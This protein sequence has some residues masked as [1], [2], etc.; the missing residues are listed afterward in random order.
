MISIIAAMTE[1]H[2]IARDGGIPWHVPEDLKL[3]RELTTGHAVVMGRKTFQSMGKPLKG[4]LNIVISS[5]LRGTEDDLREDN[6]LICPS[7]EEA[8]A[9][10]EGE[11]RDI[12]IIGGTEVYRR[13]LPVADR[14]YLSIMKK[15]YRGDTFFP[16]FNEAE[17][18]KTSIKP[19]SGF[20][21]AVYER[22][23]I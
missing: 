22:N 18:R 14:M 21:L 6:L 23:P 3:F 16:P 20:D 2:V 4:R 19:F 11:N 8:I 9:A 17:W 10:A 5:T 15:K 7:F 1:D 12:F 13:A